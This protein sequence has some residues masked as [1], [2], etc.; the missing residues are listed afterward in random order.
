MLPREEYIEQAYFFR[1][2]W[3]RLSD[4]I[5]MQE[6]FRTL[7]DEVLSTTKMPLAIDYMLNEMKHSGTVAPAMAKLH[8]YFS[9]YQTFVI[10]EAENERGRFDLRVA[11]AILRH[12]AEY[13][14]SEPTRPGLFMFQFETLC[15]NR[16]R[17]DRGLAAMSNDP[18][19]GEIWGKWILTVSRQIGLVDMSD[20]I[21]VRSEYY[22]QRQKLR[23]QEEQFETLFGEKEGK[24]AFA[25]RRKDPLL[26]FAA[27]QRQLG[28][29]KVPR[30]EPPDATPAMIPLLM[31]RID[32][33]ESRLKLMEEEQRGGIDLT[34][35]YNPNQKPSFD[36]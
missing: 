35:F 10:Q 21:Y 13:L 34:K 23:G 2:V 15:R 16:L 14:S 32:R 11:L 9:P 25:N 30:A 5:P 33:L 28:Y 20:L 6:A 8:H 4:N 22:R 29:P 18:F 19:F 1:V 36:D 24:I 31:R 17:Y 27:L 7:K 26:L 12:Q 3:E